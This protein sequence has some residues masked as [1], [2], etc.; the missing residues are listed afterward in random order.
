MRIRRDDVAGRT[1]AGLIFG[2]LLYGIVAILIGLIFVPK[3]L[4][5]T[6]GVILGVIAASLFLVNMY[7]SID[8]S[9]EMNE[10][11]AKGFTFGR[12]TVRLIIALLVMVVTIILDTYMFAGAA[13]GLFTI[14]F[15]AL[16]HPLIDKLIDKILSWEE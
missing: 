14:K 6:A 7:D 12:K 13:I 16:T 15:S 2:C 3:K 4:L 11:K 1:L 10:K 9:L 8:A 5:F